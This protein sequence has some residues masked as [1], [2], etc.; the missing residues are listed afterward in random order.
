MI[1]KIPAL[2]D[3]ASRRGFANTYDLLDHS[4]G[5]LEFGTTR[6]QAA[7]R[8]WHHHRPCVDA[9]QRLADGKWGRGRLTWSD[10]TGWSAS[11]SYQYDMLDPEN[12]SLTLG[13]RNR[14]GGGEWTERKQTLRLVYTVIDGAKGESSLLRITTPKL[15]R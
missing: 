12:A 4:H 9:A 7:Q 15:H 8:G 2:G 5:R 11:I 10:G 6:R 3:R 14:R 13:Y 1:R